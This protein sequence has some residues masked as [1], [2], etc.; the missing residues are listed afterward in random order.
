M[1]LSLPPVNDRADLD[2]LDPAARAAFLER[3]ARSLWRLERDDAH[4]RWIAVED[5]RAIERFGFTVDDFPNAPKPDLPD[6]TPLPA[7][8]VAR[9]TAPPVARVTALQGLLAL[10]AAGLAAA[11]EAW[12][13]AP[14]RTFAERAFIQRAGHWARDDATLLSAATTLGLTEAQIDDLFS[15]AATL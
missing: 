3:L 1:P 11:Y 2:A 9:V 10:D 4:Q 15:L 6:W 8:P 12:A 5:P 14:D 7:P 13:T